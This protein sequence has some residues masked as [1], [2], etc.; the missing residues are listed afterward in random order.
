M[1]VALGFPDE[2]NGPNAMPTHAAALFADRHAAHAAVEQ[3]A[4]AGFGRDEMTVAMSNEAFEREFGAAA[5]R[6]S[7][8]RPAA[9]SGGVLPAIVSGLKALEVAEG[10]SL[11]AGG[12]LVD[13]LLR[14]RSLGAALFT[15]GVGAHE[16]RTI[17]HGL[18]RDQIFVGVHTQ[19]ERGTL[20]RQLL[21]L[22]GGELTQA[23]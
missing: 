3:L 8:V 14:E 4:Q 7:G 10:A 9:Y 21:A 20:A 18:L 2:P 6:T 19:D 23:A 15:L 16:A 17:S 1:Y 13:P 5:A 11:R 12:P 22:A